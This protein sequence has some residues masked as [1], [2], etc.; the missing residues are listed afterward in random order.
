MIPTAENI[1]SVY[2]SASNSAFLEGLSWYDGANSF[3][4]SL[5]GNRFMR[6]AGVIAALSPMNRWENN[7]L[8]AAQLYAQNGDGTGCGL[9][10]NVAKAIAIYNGDDALD[11]L[12]GNKV[13]AFFLTI[14]DPSGIH[15]PVIDRHAFDIAIGQRTNDKARSRLERKGE[16]ERFSAAY[17]DAARI[18][19]IG[20]AQ[21]QAITW[22]AW[23]EQHGILY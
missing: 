15:D 23:K 5:D 8:K 12:G 2:R 14:A 9:F 10:G 11:V 1:L 16:Y 6:A 13:R 20:A 18:A 22:V 21:V 17:C 3:A 4:R 19:G 7:K